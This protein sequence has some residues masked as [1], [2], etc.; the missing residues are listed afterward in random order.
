VTLPAPD[1]LGVEAL[2]IKDAACEGE[3][4]GAIVV[5][6]TGGTPPYIYRWSNNDFGNEIDFLA[7]GSY[8]VTVT[9]RNNCMTVNSFNVSQPKPLEV[10][11]VTEPASNELGSDCN[12]SV[13][14]MVTGGKEPYSYR[15]ININ[16]SRENMVTGLCPGEYI[17]E[18]TDALGCFPVEGS[19]IVYDRTQPCFSTRTVI[20]PDGDGLN[21][22][23]IIFC[24]DEYPDN[25]LKIYNRWGELVYQKQN[26]DCTQ[27]GGECFKGRRGE[28]QDA[29]AEALPE[30]AYYWILE[31]RDNAT[32]ED[33][34]LKGSLTILEA[35]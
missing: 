8:T 26:Y 17:V 35:N 34:I 5:A 30:G 20:T 9:D 4:D 3:R 11:V 32:G 19:G 1:P 24:A 28:D 25:L 13:R 6:A 27:N 7:A 23:F 14:A 21:E 33:V 29:A 12:G 16:N 18:V 31:Y 15:W 10:T 2:N 22:S